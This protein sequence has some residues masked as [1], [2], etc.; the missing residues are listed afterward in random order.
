MG[1]A[2]IHR[3][4]H[5]TPPPPPVPPPFFLISNQRHGAARFPPEAEDA[6]SLLKIESM[7]LRST[8]FLDLRHDSFELVS[9]D[10]IGCSFSVFL[11]F[12]EATF[13]HHGLR[14]GHA[15]L[16]HLLTLLTVLFSHHSCSLFSLRS[17]QS[18]QRSIRSVFFPAI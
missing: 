4:P 9:L 1:G 17:S 6:H 8:C 5:R 16:S 7:V 15:S 13:S 10:C 12:L 3:V 11:F 18:S 14:P 2:F